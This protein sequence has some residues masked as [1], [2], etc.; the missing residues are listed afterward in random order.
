MTLKKRKLRKV[1]FY[2][3]SKH[4]REN[5]KKSSKERFELK[6]YFRKEKAKVYATQRVCVFQI[7]KMISGV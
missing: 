2:I 3:L 1:L 7:E 6:T 5:R 4:S